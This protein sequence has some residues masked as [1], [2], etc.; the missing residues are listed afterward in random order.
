MR[1]QKQDEIA[2]EKA[3]N[4]AER[5]A[6]E[7]EIRNWQNCLT[8]AVANIPTPDGSTPLLWYVRRRSIAYRSSVEGMAIK[9]SGDDVGTSAIVSNR[10]SAMGLQ[11]RLNELST[12][13]TPEANARISALLAAPRI[14]SSN[15]LT[16]SILGDLEKVAAG[17]IESVIPAPAAIATASPV[18]T[19]SPFSTGGINLGL[20]VKQQHRSGFDLQRT[21][22]IRLNEAMISGRATAVRTDT[23]LGLSESEVLDLASDYSSNRLGEGLAA[24]ESVLGADWA[25]AKAAVFLGDNSLALPIDNAF[26]KA[27]PDAVTEMAKALGDATKKKDVGVIREILAR[28]GG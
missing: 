19:I 14:A 26:Q 9:I 7:Q 23:K 16:A 20:T 18:E 11:R 28:V 22:A 2:A 3:V 6:F 25:D 12:K 21:G 1:R 27:K 10:M 24:V 5:Q 13:A 4:E 17:T 15:L 8:E